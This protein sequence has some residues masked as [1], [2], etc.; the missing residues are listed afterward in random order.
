[1]AA[2]ARQKPL[3]GIEGGSRPVRRI[4]LREGCGEDE[5]LSDD[6]DR[7]PSLR[8]E[9]EATPSGAGHKSKASKMSAYNPS[10]FP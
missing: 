2:R 9:G 8:R 10:D 4:V 6:T 3:T 7:Q 5:Y 1:V